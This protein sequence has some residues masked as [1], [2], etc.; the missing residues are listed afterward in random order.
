MKNRIKVEC[1]P[2]IE[3]IPADFI[4]MWRQLQPDFDSDI[5]WYSVFEKH[6]GSS[7]GKL[8]YVTVY[9]DQIATLVL[10]ATISENL[11][12][13]FKSRKISLFNNFYFNRF[14]IIS[15][16]QDVD[17]LQQTLSAVFDHL[18]MDLK[19]DWIDLQPLLKG[20]DEFSI[21]TKTLKEKR[22]PF[23]DYFRFANW[24][25][26]PVPITSEEYF[27]TLNSRVKNTMQRKRKAIEKIDGFK[28]S[29]I[30]TESEFKSYFKDYIAVYNSSWKQKEAG[31][32]FIRDACCAMAEKG[33]LRLG[34]VYLKDI[35]IAAQIWFVVGNKASIFKLAYD[36]EYKKLSAGTV[37]TAEMIKQAIDVD[38]VTVIDYLSG[39]DSYKAGWMNLRRQMIGVSAFNK[40]RIMG[41][42]MWLRHKL[43]PQIYRYCCR[44]G[45]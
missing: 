30:V 33:I 7:Y 21:I 11:F 10:P 39:D 1:Y 5:A 42:I 29:I 31:I 15:Q 6:Y 45:I 41:V 4:S 26:S 19:S 35:P 12:F 34:L 3:K 8:H 25:Y 43:I 22:L 40:R 24:I 14:S 37:L 28:I 16:L 38:G 2:S 17:L 9:I 13:V 20:G 27:N 23:I 18:I 32:G 36:E 44:K